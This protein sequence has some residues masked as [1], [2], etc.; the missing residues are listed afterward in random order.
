MC[1][2]HHDR[3][4]SHWPDLIYMPFYLSH[5]TTYTTEFNLACLLDLDTVVD[6]TM[7]LPLAILLH[8]YPCV[9]LDTI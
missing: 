8:W 1:S 7:Y 9:N 3:D 2:H 6:F 4:D 5:V